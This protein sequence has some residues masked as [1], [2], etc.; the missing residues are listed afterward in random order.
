[1]VHLP[2]KATEALL[3]MLE[4]FRKYNE[5]IEALVLL[6][7]ED[8]HIAHAQTAMLIGDMEQALVV[9]FTEL[10]GEPDIEEAE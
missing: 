8:S 7:I 5:R 4:A 10:F 3:T 6:D 9:I 2:H 1:M